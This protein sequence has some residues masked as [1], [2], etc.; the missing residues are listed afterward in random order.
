MI[1]TGIYE[2]DV[3][4]SL[5]SMVPTIVWLWNVKKVSDTKRLS[6]LRFIAYI[7][8]GTAFHL[9]KLKERK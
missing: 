3:D 8:R 5:H 9:R 2:T 6:V 4:L 7:A 1:Q